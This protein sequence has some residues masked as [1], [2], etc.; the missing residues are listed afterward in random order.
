MA[1]LTNNDVQQQYAAAKAKLLPIAFSTSSSVTKEQRD[2]AEAA[3]DD[4]NDNYIGNAVASIHERTRQFQEFID[5]MERAIAGLSQN[6]LL[7]GLQQVQG[8]LDQ[9]KALLA[10]ANGGANPG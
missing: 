8:V 10:A 9:S 4:L 1:D 5:L 7:P 3:L 6:S 2:A